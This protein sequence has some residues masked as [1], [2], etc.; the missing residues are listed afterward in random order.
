MP[1]RQAGSC[2]IGYGTA[3]DSC[4]SIELRDRDKAGMWLMPATGDHRGFD[5]EMDRMEDLGPLM[6]PSGPAAPRR[7]AD[8][9][10]RP[11]GNGSRA[12]HILTRASMDG[13]SRLGCP[14]M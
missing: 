7:G 2:T 4:S 8:C 3:W 9:S 6:T 11:S 1:T 13:T 10:L 5:V 14:T 12:D